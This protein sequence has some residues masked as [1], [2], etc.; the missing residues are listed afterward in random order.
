MVSTKKQQSPSI[1]Q[2]IHLLSMSNWTVSIFTNIL[3]GHC[4]A[5]TSYL[6]QSE[7]EIA[8]VDDNL[9]SLYAQFNNILKMYTIHNI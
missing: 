8:R 7:M 3:A 6:K 1:E 4:K 5:G 2:A 9:E